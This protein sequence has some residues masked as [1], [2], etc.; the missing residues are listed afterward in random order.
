MTRL[1]TLITSLT[2]PL[3][4][5]C[6][7]GAADA[8]IQNL[9]SRIIAIET[10]LASIEDS[11]RGDSGSSH[12]YHEEATLE[13][14]RAGEVAETQTKE[15]T[16]VIEDGDTLGSIAR[17]HEVERADLLTANSLSEGQPIYIGET[18]LIPGTV[19]ETAPP[20]KQEVAEAK[21]SPAPAAPAPVAPA[22]AAEN[23]VVV[24]E[25]KKPTKATNYTVVRGETLSSIARENNTTVSTLKAANGL[26]S[27]TLA[28]GQSL[29]VPA[30]ETQNVVHTETEGKSS[31][32]AAYEYDNPLLRTNETYG[33]YTVRKGDNL[34]ALARDFFSSMPE[35]QRLNR[36]GDSTLIYP[37]NELIVPTG[38]Y[39][40]YHNSS[41][42]AQR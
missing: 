37:G 35:L 20:K 29:N 7:A 17:K 42:V 36:L 1:M 2:A 19:V 23:S 21:K 16:Y 41:G 24:G 25:T 11:L 15:Q 3:L 40:S 28:V 9:N 26:R 38:K 6:L 30:A 33:H 5:T 12:S 10:R 34:Y 39:N 27:D 32:G 14:T 18:L 31:Q 22:P 4:F 13:A 8:N